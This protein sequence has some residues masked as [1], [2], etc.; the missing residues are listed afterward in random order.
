MQNFANQWFLL[1][2]M[3]VVR[4]SAFSWFC[5]KILDIFT[6]LF[7]SNFIWLI[8]INMSKLFMVHGDLYGVFTE[9]YHQEQCWPLKKLSIFLFYH[10]WIASI[11]KVHENV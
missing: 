11:P 7:L 5:V 3:F 9:K 2:S 4:V 6:H 1:I 8:V 10:K